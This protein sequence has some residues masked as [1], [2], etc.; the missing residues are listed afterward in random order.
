VR[1]F[2]N[3]H[4]KGTRRLLDYSVHTSTRTK[5][6][7]QDIDM[8]TSMASSQQRRA[9]MEVVI[10]YIKD[11]LFARVKFLY[12]ASDLAVGGKIYED[13]LK[14]CRDK[15][16]GRVLNEV[17]RDTYMEAV[18]TT[19]MTKH[20]QKNALA[21]KRSA[22]YT[23]MQNKFSGKSVPSCSCGQ[24]HYVSLKLVKFRFVSNL[25]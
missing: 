22:V 21:Q 23:V 10:K 18:W 17:G 5:T 12:D 13:Y 20:I 3:E 14:K 11:D 6:T 7:E 16:G 9:E 4:K 25:C 15:L 19:A 24:V 1:S 8:S 2:S